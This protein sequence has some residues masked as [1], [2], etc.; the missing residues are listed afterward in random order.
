MTL[1][2]AEAR[3]RIAKNQL[4]FYTEKNLQPQMYADNSG[5]RFRPRVF[6][7]K[8]LVFGWQRLI[9]LRQ[10]L[11]PPK[12]A[13]KRGASPTVSLAHH[14]LVPRPREGTLHGLRLMLT[15]MGGCRTVLRRCLRSSATQRLRLWL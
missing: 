10:S 8:F 11:H 14:G 1:G 15:P 13:V 7:V 9:N 3:A 4:R 5:R 12:S 6:G 2:A